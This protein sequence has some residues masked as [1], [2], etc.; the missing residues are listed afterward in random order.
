MVPRQGTG[1]ENSQADGKTGTQDDSCAEFS[2]DENNRA[3]GS[4]IKV[5]QKIGEFTHY[6][7]HTTRTAC[8][9]ARAPCKMK[10]KRQGLLF[11]NYEEF[12]GGESRVL[13]QVSA[14]F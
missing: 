4:R 12:Q 10:M 6:Q 8:V 1:E 14:L 9:I 5:S 7:L 2:L 11:K 3:E 13:K